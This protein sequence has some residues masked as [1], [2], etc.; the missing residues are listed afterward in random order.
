[1]M[2]NLRAKWDALVAAA[3]RYS[4]YTR[5]VEPY[6]NKYTAW[7]VGHPNVA[8]ALVIAFALLAIF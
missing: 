3:Q 4:G 5:F 6:W 7:L 1:M 8:G 2:D